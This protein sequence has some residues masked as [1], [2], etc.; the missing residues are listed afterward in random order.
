M[1]VAGRVAAA[2][3]V[4]RRAAVVQMVGVVMHELVALTRQQCHDEP[5]GR[6]AGHRCQHVVIARR[7]HHHR[8]GQRRRRHGRQSVAVV[9][10]VVFFFHSKRIKQTIQ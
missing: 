4:T 9:S 10:P 2:A 6:V 3:A 5:A 7:A 1:I 8:I